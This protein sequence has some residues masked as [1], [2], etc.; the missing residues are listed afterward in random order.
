MKIIYEGWELEHFNKANNF[1]NYQL[2]IFSKYIKGSVAEIGPGSDYIN[3][4]KRYSDK[5]IKNIELFEPSLTLFS[6]LKKKIKKKKFK[7]F[8][9]EFK[10]K[11]KK[12][13]T[14]LYLDVLEHIKKDKSEVEKALSCLKDNGFLIINVPAYQFLYS[15]FDESVGHWKRYKKKDF[16]KILINK[17][18][19]NVMM[20]YYDSLGFILSLLSKIFKISHITNFNKKI[21]LWDFLIP[22]SKLIDIITFNSFGKSLICI[23]RK[24]RITRR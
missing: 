24:K 23:I 1:R 13:D 21:F 4:K 8:N 17:K 18:N 11:T 15:K 7:I 22:I 3:I 6:Q 2:E 9:K 5:R 10:K 14:I 19:I 12:Y 16:Q 20:F